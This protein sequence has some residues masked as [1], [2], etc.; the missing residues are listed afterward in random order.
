MQHSAQ[1]APANHELEQLDL[2]YQELLQT[3]IYHLQSGMKTVSCDMTLKET[4]LEQ[5]RSFQPTISDNT[6]PCQYE[7]RIFEQHFTA[8]IEFLRGVLGQ[9]GLLSTRRNK[10][11]YLRELADSLRLYN[12]IFPINLPVPDAKFQPFVDTIASE[13]NHFGGVLSISNGRIKPVVDIIKKMHLYLMVTQAERWVIG[14][15]VRDACFEYAILDVES[16]REAL[17]ALQESLADGGKDFDED[18]LPYMRL[19]EIRCIEIK[20]SVPVAD[21]I[22]VFNNG[23]NSNPSESDQISESLARLQIPGPWPES[24]S[25][26][27][28]GLE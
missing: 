13:M 23:P 15:A 5:M 6:F 28:D 1:P 19:S 26:S 24:E 3:Y 9:F 20:P 27:D 7:I 14:G 2:K 17:K 21:R 10:D 16:R 8:W 11:Y 22:R 4:N 18:E 12:S 25:G